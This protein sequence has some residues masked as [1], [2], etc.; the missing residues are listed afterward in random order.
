[1]VAC[2]AFLERHK[3]ALDKAS[4]RAFDRRSPDRQRFGDPLVCPALGGFA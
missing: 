1:M 2:V 4:A 3:V